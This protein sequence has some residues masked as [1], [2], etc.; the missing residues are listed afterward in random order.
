MD[1]SVAANLNEIQNLTPLK[2]YCKEENFLGR[3]GY[4]E[5][6]RGKFDKNRDIA[7]KRI[8]IINDKNAE[9]VVHF[10]LNHQNILYC[11]GV[12]KDEVYKYYKLV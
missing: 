6:Y 11:L 8:K 5:V 1:A 10:R 12:E 7:I 3:G 4:G 9:V 2:D